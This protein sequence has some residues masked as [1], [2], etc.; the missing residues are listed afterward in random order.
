M[1]HS[2]SCTLLG[3]DLNRKWHEANKWQYPIL[4][5]VKEYIIAQSEVSD[6]LL[7]CSKGNI[8][9]QKHIK[10]SDISYN[11]MK[12]RIF[13][14][15][16][17]LDFVIDLHANANLKGLYIMGNSY[18]S[19][20]RYERHVVFPKMMTQNC[21]DFSKENTIYNADEEKEGTCRR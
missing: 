9:A 19:V 10:T 3:S 12:L 11:L 1:F 6:I 13:L 14:Q 7:L 18:D 20:Y 5:A 2:H 16:H 8:F 4:W 21:K 15:N 17:Q